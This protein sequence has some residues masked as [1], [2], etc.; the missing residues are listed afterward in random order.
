MEEGVPPH[1]RAVWTHPLAAMCFVHGEH[2]APYATCPVRIVS[3][4]TLFGE[5]G[6]ET[7]DRDT[8]LEAA[9][10][11]DRTMLSRVE[12]A[13]RQRGSASELLRLRFAVRDVVDALATQARPP[14]TPALMHAFEG[15]FVQ[16]RS[17]VAAL[18]LPENWWADIDAVTRL[19]YVRTAL[20]ILSEPKYPAA[21]HAIRDLLFLLTT[22]LPRRVVAELSERSMLWPNDLRR[23]WTYA[24]AVGA[25]GGYVF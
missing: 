3:S 10:F 6:P 12:K 17:L 18:Q 16:R 20:L 21:D 13:L 7:S 25:V 19:L 11:D 5:E 9:D 24:A 23:R 8:A 1:V 14:R 2:L 15:S 4:F 22:E